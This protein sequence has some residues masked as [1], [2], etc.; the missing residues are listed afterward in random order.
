MTRKLPERIS[1]L[2]HAIGRLFPFSGAGLLVLAL[3]AAAFWFQGLGKM[4]LVLLAAGFLGIL[5]T[6]LMAFLNAAA[7]LWLHQRWKRAGMRRGALLECDVAQPTGL[8][9]P[10]PRRFPLLHVEWSWEEPASVHVLP[11]VRGEFAESVVP[12]KRGIYPRVVRK[13]SVT[14]ILGLTAISWRER[15]QAEISILPHRGALDQMTLLEGLAA[16]EDLCDPRGDPYGDRVDMR[17]YAP[18]D[19]PRLILWK[20]YARTR[21]LLVRINERALAARPRSCA[22]L[23]AGTGDEAGAGLMRVILERG[24]LGESWRF[25]ADGNANYACNLPEALRLITQSGNLSPDEGT[26]LPDYLAQAE[27]DGYSA[28]F[29]VV[30][31]T[32]GPWIEPVLAAILRTQLRPHLYT[33]LDGTPDG[34]QMEPRWKHWFLKAANGATGALEDAALMAR[35]FAGISIPFLLADRHAGKICGDIRVLLEKR[36]RAERRR[37]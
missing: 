12:G 34:L 11:P 25:G 2:M 5:V 28:C 36:Q 20:S 33:A 6:L 10:W 8:L 23:V 29:L 14:D 18:G 32:E 9:V 19:S 16:G 4:D 3:C 7:S 31:P 35:H 27:K 1:N 22:Y 13:V 24:F 21:K 15:E 37:A 30:P 17:Q 26:G